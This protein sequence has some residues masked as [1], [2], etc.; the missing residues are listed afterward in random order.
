MLVDKVDL[1]VQNGLSLTN[2]E[3]FVAC[4]WPP[5]SGLGGGVSI[6]ALNEL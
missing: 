6:M 3:Q 2:I 1:R 4:F 5:D